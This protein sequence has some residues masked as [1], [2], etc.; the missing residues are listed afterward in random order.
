MLYVEFFPVTRY[1][2]V[3]R[4]A[5]IQ[6]THP[7]NLI[8][9][10]INLFLYTFIYIFYIYSPISLTFLIIVVYLYSCIRYFSR[11]S[12]VGVWA[13][14][15]ATNFAILFHTNL[16]QILCMIFIARSLC[17][18]D[19]SLLVLLWFSFSTFCCFGRQRFF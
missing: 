17:E 3:Y 5:L 13:A 9:L 6:H 4:H 1:T 7:H 16:W 18:S 15:P 10:L 11:N 12:F 8:L 19:Y 14:M 2:C